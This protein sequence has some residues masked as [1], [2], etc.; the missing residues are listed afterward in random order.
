[1]P[2]L[3]YAGFDSPPNRAAPLPSPLLCDK[4]SLTVTDGLG[5]MSVSAGR[6]RVGDLS[7]Q[8]WDA[9][10]AATGAF[11]RTP[12]RATTAIMRFGSISRQATLGWNT[13]PGTEQA[14]IQVSGSGVIK[15][16]VP[17][18]DIGSF[19]IN[20]DY[21]FV[22]VLR[23]T[24][25]F[26]IVDDTLLWVSATGNTAS[27]QV[28]LNDRNQPS[29]S[30]DNLP[31]IDLGGAWASDYGIARAY[32]ASPAAITPTFGASLIEDDTLNGNMETGDPPTAWTA[33]IAT[34]DGVADERTGGAGAQ[35]I[36]VVNNAVA[37]QYAKQSNVGSAA[38]GTW[39]QLSVWIRKVTSNG[40]A[41]HRG[42]GGTVMVTTAIQ[43]S[44]DW[45]NFVVIGRSI[46]AGAASYVLLRNVSAVDTEE[47][48]YD[49]VSI[50]PIT[51]SSTLGTVYDKHADYLAEVAVTLNSVGVQAGLALNVDDETNP[52]NGIFIYVDGTN[53]VM[54]KLVSGTW[55]DLISTAVTYGAGKRLVV[56]KDGTSVTAYYDNAKIGTTQT[57]SDATV[58]DNTKHTWFG[59]HSG[60]SYSL[61]C[62]WPRTV[63]LPPGL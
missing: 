61:F 14:A 54:S 31:V 40:Y 56:I 48:R 44:T 41:Q 23:S 26:I 2:W 52:A 13:A 59:T 18:L 32:E 21:Q 16:H 6:L 42:T 25:H 10:M 24:G 34:V 15:D 37:A 3:F 57:I 9:H 39:Q 20:T 62:L 30:M 29:L 43:T 4:G 51:L 28:I 60:N 27:L 45:A 17:N 36:S 12:G 50:K 5:I 33:G 7:G 53:L 58:K 22:I 19:V 8:A 35:S 1:M 47:S 63:D 11:A 49:D 46:D 55:T 38:V